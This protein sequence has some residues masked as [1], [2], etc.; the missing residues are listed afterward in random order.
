M[1]SGTVGFADVPVGAS[2]PKQSYE[3]RFADAT[4]VFIG[5]ATAQR[6]VPDSFGYKG[7]RGETT[8]Q[9][10]EIWKGEHKDGLLAVRT[11]D[12]VDPLTTEGVTCG[13]N[14]FRVGSRYLVFAYGDPLLADTDCEGRIQL[15]E[16]AGDTLEWLSA[17]PS[18]VVTPR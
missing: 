15:V 18:T 16:R 2:C 12:Y 6:L 4:A 13:G 1:L 10:Q 14:R 9:V 8:L 5:R 3:R 11:C 17:K 7:I